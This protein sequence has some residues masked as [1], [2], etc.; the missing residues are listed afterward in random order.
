[1]KCCLC[2]STGNY[3]P[4]ANRGARRQQHLVQVPGLTK[5][6][7]GRE[8]DDAWFCAFHEIELGETSQKKFGLEVFE[9]FVTAGELAKL[10]EVQKELRG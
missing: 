7:K 10:C 5:S 6:S 2:G 3:Q 4:Q 1:M 8:W 9:R